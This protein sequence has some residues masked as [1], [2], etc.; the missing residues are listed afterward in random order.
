MTAGRVFGAHCVSAPAA[1][2]GWRRCLDGR[3]KLRLPGCPVWTGQSQ[4]AL[5]ADSGA[6]ESWVIGE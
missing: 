1:K 6:G 2:L 4:W 5:S 3:L